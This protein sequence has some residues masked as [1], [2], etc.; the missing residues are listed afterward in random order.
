MALLDR[1]TSLAV[2]LATVAVVY[3][4][5]QIHMPT[6]VDARAADPGD[7]N[8]SG[9]ERS[10]AWTAT[11]AVA[12]ISL[13]AKDP[14]VFI[15]GGSTVIALSW[16]HKHANMLDTQIGSAVMPQ[17][18]QTMEQANAMGAGFSPSA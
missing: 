2:G 10:A 11:A 7:A 12:G 9:S 16:L 6:L 8:L 3:G 13:L 5:Y 14:T 18:R 17:S 1:K 15:L 4:I